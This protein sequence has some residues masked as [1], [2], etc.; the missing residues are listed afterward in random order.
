MFGEEMLN[1]KN[2]QMSEQTVIG[3]L[4]KTELF[5]DIFL[6]TIDALPSPFPLRV[7]RTCANGITFTI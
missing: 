6:Q 7:P 1:D 5:Q 3:K 2:K 4:N